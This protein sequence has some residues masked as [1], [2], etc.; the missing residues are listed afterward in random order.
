MGSAF[1]MVEAAN[2]VIYDT[3]WCRRVPRWSISLGICIVG[4]FMSMLFTS[5]DGL[6][7]LDVV[8]YYNGTYIL[9]SLGIWQCFGCGWA[10]GFTE[11][12]SL[13]GRNS[14]L[15]FDVGYWFFMVI[16]GL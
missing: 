11:R 5:K 8:D 9:L 3:P 15:T 2:T 10:Y 4:L 12:A 1:A 14:A 6:Y 7:Y 16:S 13:V